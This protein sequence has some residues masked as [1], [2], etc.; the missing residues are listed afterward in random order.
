MYI[1]QVPNEG[2]KN[3]SQTFNEEFPNI[4]RKHPRAN[5]VFIK[6]SLMDTLHWMFHN[7]KEVLPFCPDFKMF[8]HMSEVHFLHLFNVVVDEQLFLLN[9]SLKILRLKSQI[10]S[11][12][13]LS[14]MQSLQHLVIGL[15]NDTVF[16]L[17]QTAPS[18]EMRDAYI[19]SKNIMNRVPISFISKLESCTLKFCNLPGWSNPTNAIQSTTLKSLNLSFNIIDDVNGWLGKLPELTYLNIGSNNIHKF[20]ILSWESILKKMPKLEVLD[21]SMHR[22]I[23]FLF[24]KR[25]TQKWN[26]DGNQFKH[27]KELYLTNI[28][29]PNIIFS[30]TFTKLDRLGI[31]SSVWHHPNITFAPSAH[32]PMIDEFKSSSLVVPFFIVPSQFPAISIYQGSYLLPENAENPYFISQTSFPNMED[33]DFDNLVFELIVTNPTKTITFHKNNGENAL[34]YTEWDLADPTDWEGGQFRFNLRP[35]FTFYSDGVRE[36]SNP[37]QQLEEALTTLSFT[38]TPDLGLRAEPYFLKWVQPQGMPSQTCV[39]C[40]AGMPVN[41]AALDPP[42]DNHYLNQEQFV[43]E[44]EIDTAMCTCNALRSDVILTYNILHNIAGNAQSPELS[45]AEI[46]LIVDK[47][48]EHFICR[49]CYRM[50]LFT[51]AKEDKPLKC[52]LFLTYFCNDR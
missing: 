39:L 12:P 9:G 29:I 33:D 4:R 25:F 41:Q 15:G 40:F 8:Q 32:F 1:D 19:V 18:Q 43:D 13:N 45:D 28:D 37:T 22:I 35:Y 7:D 50:H 42:M 6:G 24:S 2:S 3:I 48:H 27:L 10:T 46:D 49:N 30:N 16:F 23:H 20:S 11:I 26:L 14:S 44:G 5:T 51:L 36:R 47:H 21:I 52:P 38:E 17:Q 34:M 31:D